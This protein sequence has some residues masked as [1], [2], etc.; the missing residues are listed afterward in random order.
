MPSK[1]DSKVK[2]AW[3]EA[4]RLRRLEC[5]LTQG[6]LVARIGMSG[7]IV[8][9]YEYGRAIPNVIIGQKIAESLDWTVEEWKREAER[10]I[11]DE[12]WHPQYFHERVSGGGHYEKHS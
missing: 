2:R 12:K 4:L 7:T 10:M 6:M 3:G 11:N 9:N 5:Q 8:S 1:T